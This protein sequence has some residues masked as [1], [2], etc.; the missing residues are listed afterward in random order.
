MIIQQQSTMSG[1][2]DSDESTM[3]RFLCKVP[4]FGTTAVSLLFQSAGTLCQFSIMH[5][6]MGLVGQPSI[7]VA[8]WAVTAHG[9]MRWHPEQPVRTAQAF[10]PALIPRTIRMIGP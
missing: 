7:T 10:L 9:H 3:L 1:G 2:S 4:L 6:D 8:G 5:W